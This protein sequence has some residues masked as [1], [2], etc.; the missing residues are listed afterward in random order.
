MP[1]AKKEFVDL[2]NAPP[3]EERFFASH[4][5]SE[6]HV[7]LMHVG[8]KPAAAIATKIEPAPPVKIL[9]AAISREIVARA[10][11]LRRCGV[12]NPIT[13]AREE[14]AKRWGHASGAAL[15]RW[16]RRNR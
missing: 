10:D 1:L 16:L 13:Q 14:A 15:H 11:E 8:R 12:Q 4:H 9:A 7:T 5:G 2:V 3:R 6:S